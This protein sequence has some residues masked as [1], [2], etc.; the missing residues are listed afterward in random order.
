MRDCDLENEFV[1][2]ISYGKHRAEN[3]ISSYRSDLEQFEK[4]LSC[5]ENGDTEK[6]ED[7][8]V[9]KQNPNQSES[10]LIGA[11]AGKIRAFLDSLEK[12]N[13]ST[14][15]IRRKFATLICFYNFLISQHWINDNPTTDIEPPQVQKSK[16]KILTDEQIWQI[17][18]LPSLDNWVGARD[19]AM[20]ELLCCTGIRISELIKLNINDVDL[21]ALRLKITS[22]NRRKRTLNLTGTA[23]QTINYYLKLMQRETGFDIENLQSPLFVNRFGKRLDARST[24]RRIE[25][26]ISLAGLDKSITPY[27]FRHTFAQKL[28]R[29]GIAIDELHQLLGFGSNSAAQLYVESLKTI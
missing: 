20:L 4:F 13:Y 16:P 12:S 17:L 15:S 6:L 1:K 25:K 19:R 26:Y 14:A 9:S 10:L 11:D 2:F 24:D 21:T 7:I 5:D 29:Q 23:A 27:N 28:L 8:F 22:P 3:T 18:H